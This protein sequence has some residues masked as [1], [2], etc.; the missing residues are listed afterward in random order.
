MKA[1]LFAVLLATGV[2]ALM[3]LTTRRPG[4]ATANELPEGWQ[5]DD[6]E[7][8][9]PPND[10]RG[11]AYVLAWK[12]LDDDRPL[13]VEECLVLKH[14]DQPGRKATWTLASLYRQPRLR[15]SWS[16]SEL[17]AARDAGGG[18][19][20]PERDYDVYR[21]RPTNADVDAFREKVG[22][23]LGA[24]DGFKL[25]DGRVCRRAWLDGIGEE[26]NIRFAR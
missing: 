21:S 24:G 22:W 10:V 1:L 6:I 8:A 9:T 2:L 20:S 14:F 13:R 19:D 26:P 4:S 25:I 3:L 15:N 7:R 18:N 16:V 17:A 11:T 12:I 23:S 5:L